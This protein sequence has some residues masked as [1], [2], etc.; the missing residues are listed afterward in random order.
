[1]MNGMCGGELFIFSHPL[2]DSIEIIRCHLVP[3]NKSVGYFFNHPYGMIT[4]RSQ[5]FEN[6]FQLGDLTR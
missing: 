6:K 1:M 5:I 2:R 4:I 3:T